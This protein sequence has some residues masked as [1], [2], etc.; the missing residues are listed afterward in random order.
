M[1]S[2]G[3]FGNHHLLHQRL[4]ING[5]YRGKYTVL[6]G[7][8]KVKKYKYFRKNWYVLT[9]TIF[10]MG[11]S[12]GLKIAFALYQYFMDIFGDGLT[13]K[14]VD[15]IYLIFTSKNHLVAMFFAFFIWMISVCFIL[16]IENYIIKRKLVDILQNQEYYQ[17]NV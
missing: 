8:L 3:S 6:L 7:G 5:Y 12:I 11:Y 9:I 16:V 1:I 4:S 2:V 13:E 14:Q 10:M 17:S 15:Q